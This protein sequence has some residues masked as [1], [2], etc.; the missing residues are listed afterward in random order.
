M[1]DSIQTISKKCENVFNEKPYIRKAYLF[2]S[3]SKN[4][5]NDRS[6]IDIVCELSEPMTTDFFSLYPLLEDVTNKKIDIYSI[7]ELDKRF[8]KCIKKDFVKIYE[9]KN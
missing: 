2:G 4:D 5:A 7:D 9:R 8:L 1:I 3:Y 6:D